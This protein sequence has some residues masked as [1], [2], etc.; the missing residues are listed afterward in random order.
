MN[1]S[2]QCKVPRSTFPFIFETLEYMKMMDEMGQ[3][4]NQGFGWELQS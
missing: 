1:N 2:K 3:A 4:N